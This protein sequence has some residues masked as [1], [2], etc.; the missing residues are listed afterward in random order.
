MDPFSSEV[1][2]VERLF[3]VAVAVG[4]RQKAVDSLKPGN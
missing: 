1:Y 4:K 2:L 3:R